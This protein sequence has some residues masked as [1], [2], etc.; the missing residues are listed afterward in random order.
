M[1]RCAECGERNLSVWP[2][3]VNMRRK[4]VSIWLTV[5][6]CLDCAETLESLIELKADGEF[7]TQHAVSGNMFQPPAA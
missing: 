2:T 1:D 7:R 5:A 6:L 3:M 4:G